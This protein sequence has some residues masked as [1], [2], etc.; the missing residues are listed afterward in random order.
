MTKGDIIPFGQ[1]NWRVLDVKDRQVLLISETILELRWYH[2][3]FADTT[4]SDCALRQY[5][6]HEFYHQFSPDE[7]VQIIT[8]TNQN[9]NNP[10]FNTKGGCDTTDRL[11]LLSLQ[12]VCLYFG[13]STTHLQNKDRQRWLIDD[14]NNSQ[15]QARYGSNFHWWRLRSPGYYARTGASVNAKGNVYVR[16]NGVYGRPRDGGGV[17]PALWRETKHLVRTFH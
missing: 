8:T 7:K 2:N 10:W 5:L 9:L 6:N 12:E 13:D 11:F 16:G 3:Q 14:D 1:Y 4:W 17:R 15:R